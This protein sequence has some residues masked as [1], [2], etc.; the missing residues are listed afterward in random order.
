MLLK[1][2]LVLYRCFWRVLM[3][4]LCMVVHVLCVYASKLLSGFV[5]ARSVFFR[6]RQ[7]GKPVVYFS[8]IQ[9]CKPGYAP[10]SPA[11]HLCSTARI[12]RA[13]AQPH[14]AIVNCSAAV[15][16]VFYS[17]FSTRNQNFAVMNSCVAALSV[18]SS[19]IPTWSA[20]SY[21][22]CNDT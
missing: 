11:A 22:Q 3:S 10:P 21:I 9:S 7:V 14:F 4:I 6:W 12:R 18:F 16:S 19:D 5:G 15:M 1:I 2:G 20:D 8:K 13:L 17:P